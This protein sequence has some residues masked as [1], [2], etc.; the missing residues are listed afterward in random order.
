MTLKAY[1]IWFVENW[2][3]A[4]VILG[5][6][7]TIYLVEVVLPQNV[8]LFALMMYTPL[9]TLHEAE[10]YVFPGGFAEFVNRNIYKANPENGLL[11]TTAIFWINM[12]VWFFFPLS[13]FQAITNLDAAGW[14][15]YFVI[16]Q[17]VVHLAI[18]IAG[19]RFFNPGMYTAWLVHVPW[20]IWT[21]WLLMKAGAIVN[22][23]WNGY[24]QAGLLINLAFPV[25]G[26]MLWVRYKRKLRGQKG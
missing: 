1:Y 17:A 2:A 24:L 25:A 16:F 8:L 4:G 14:M 10:E 11:D 6:F 21:I 20:A 15:P 7:L 3:K 12:V 19:K 26:F 22:P 13:G 9:Y 23:Y 5:I 18:G